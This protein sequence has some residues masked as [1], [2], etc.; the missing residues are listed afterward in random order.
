MIKKT[1]LKALLSV[2]ALALVVTG[3]SIANDAEEKIVSPQPNQTSEQI[4]VVE[5]FGTAAH[6]VIP[7]NH[8]LRNG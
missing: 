6:I 5:F 4:K 1:Q 2:L 8:T 7:S 3:N